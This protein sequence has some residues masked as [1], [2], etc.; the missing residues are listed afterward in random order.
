M[1]RQIQAHMDKT[2]SPSADQGKIDEDLEQ[3]ERDETLRQQLA[4]LLDSIDGPNCP[5]SRSWCTV[6]TWKR[7]TTRMSLP[8]HWA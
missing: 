4:E 7:I 8:A 5:S 3:F 2:V 6:W 1:A